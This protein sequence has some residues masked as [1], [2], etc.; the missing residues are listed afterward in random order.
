MMPECPGLGR[1]GDPPGQVREKGA[2]VEVLSREVNGN[3]AAHEPSP[4]AR[5]D[6]HKSRRRKPVTRLTQRD[7]A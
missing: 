1:E 4:P 5:P 2:R 3:G 7:R 6:I